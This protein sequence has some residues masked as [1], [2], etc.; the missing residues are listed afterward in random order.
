MMKNAIRVGVK[1]LNRL[2]N[3]CEVP[4]LL[5]SISTAYLLVVAL[6]FPRRTFPFVLLF[7]FAK[8]NFSEIVL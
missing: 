5:P 3:S 8:N 6:S 7:L 1:E 2:T 4:P